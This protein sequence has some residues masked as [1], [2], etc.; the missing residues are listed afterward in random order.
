MTTFGLGLPKG[1][2]SIYLLFCA[3]SE[4]CAFVRVCME[5]PALLPLPSLK[6]AGGGHVSQLQSSSLS[7]C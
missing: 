2:I 3:D 1:I 5:V 6:Y 4:E 7:Q